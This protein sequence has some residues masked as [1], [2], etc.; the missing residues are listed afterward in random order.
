[1][2]TAVLVVAVFLSV[3]GFALDRAFRESAETAVRDRLQGRLYGLLAAAELDSEERLVLPETLPEPLF[4]AS[5][6]GGAALIVAGDG[7]TVWR[8]GSLLDAH[9][10]PAVVLAPGESYFYRRDDDAGGGLYTLRF[11]VDWEGESG[12]LHRFTFAVAEDGRRFASQV[13][14]FRRN[15]SLWLGGTTVLLLVVLTVAL[16]WGLAPLRRVAT[17]LSEVE[18]GHRSEL[19]VGYPR[20]LSNLTGAINAFIRNE[21]ARLERYRNT[22]ADL[23][24]SLKTPLAVLRG[25]FGAENSSDVG[26]A[27]REQIDR[28]AGIVDYQLRRAATSGRTTLAKPVDVRRVV[29]KLVATLAKVY[30]EKRV[31]VEVHVGQ[32]V[33]FRGE[34]GDLL[35]IVGNLLDNAFK[36]CSG[37]VVVTA[38]TASSTLGKNPALSVC[39]EDDGPGIPAALAGDVAER[40]VRADDPASGHG[41]GLAVVGDV[42]ES[43]GGSVEYGRSVLGGARVTVQ[44]P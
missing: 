5:N 39:V 36:W 15:L 42:V 19:G 33:Q 2:L 4:A 14:A 28:M 24:H 7:Q 38:E 18:A 9:L 35:E 20:E 27:A 29:E 32:T 21:R 25:M 26:P 43:Y 3:V 22:L 41:I 37:R 30:G 11:G 40:G 13:D 34:E 16:R 12:G 10:L 8:S 6:S 31:H 17:E 23:S 44:I 1:M